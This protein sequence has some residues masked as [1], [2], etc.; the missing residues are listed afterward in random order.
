MWRGGKSVGASII[1]GEWAPLPTVPP[2]SAAD[3]QSAGK[4][5]VGGSLQ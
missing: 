2:V 4:R 1:T 5:V 3:T